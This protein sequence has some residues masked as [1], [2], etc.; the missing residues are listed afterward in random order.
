MTEEREKELDRLTREEISKQMKV[1]ANMVS[2]STELYK[3]TYK[4]MES[5][6]PSNWSKNSNINSTIKSND[7]NKKDLSKYAKV[8]LGPINNYESDSNES[9]DLKDESIS[10][11]DNDND[12]NYDDDYNE[13]KLIDTT[14]IKHKIRNN[15]SKSSNSSISSNFNIKGN[16]IPPKLN[17][18]NLPNDKELDKYSKVNHVCKNL[19]KMYRKR[20]QQIQ[21]E[22]L[23]LQ[24]IVNDIDKYSN[25]DE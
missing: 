3:N 7:N 6:L 16:S 2:T 11:N 18:L 12:D 21:S 22:L 17:W 15:K 20:Y 23:E 14:R 10:D 8:N 5:R 4:Q 9:D 19:V 25:Y 1:P 13:Q 24:Q